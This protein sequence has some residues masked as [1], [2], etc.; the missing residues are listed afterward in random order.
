MAPAV[1]GVVRVGPVYTP[2]EHRRR[3]YAASGV[4]VTSRRALA[5]GAG[6]CTLFTDIANPTSNKL[7][8][9]VGYWPVADWEE[10]VF[11]RD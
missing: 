2:P 1:T 4:A 8:A 7:Y 3:G 10:H 6:G 5:R 11:Q 9:E